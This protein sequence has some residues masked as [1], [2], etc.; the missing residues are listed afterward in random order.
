MILVAMVATDVVEVDVGGGWR[1]LEVVGGVAVVGVVEE[2]DRAASGV[3]M[4]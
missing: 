2:M 4:A 1:W 3:V